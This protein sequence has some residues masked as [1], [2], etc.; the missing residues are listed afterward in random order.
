[1]DDLVRWLRAILDAEAEE[2]LAAAEELGPDWFYDDGYVQ[3]RR[4]LDLV[5]TGSQD[6][7]EAERGR[8]IAVHDPARVLRE[9]DAKRGILARYEFACR[10][11]AELNITEQEREQRIGLAAAFGTSVQCIAEVYADRPG[12]LESW[13]P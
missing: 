5:A 1:M 4:E 13:R 6:F 2:T 3:A 9:I 11:A 12:F 10:N 8:F 7:L